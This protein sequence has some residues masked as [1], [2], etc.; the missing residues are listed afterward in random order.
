MRGA[1][2]VCSR[3]I[4]DKPAHG[5]YSGGEIIVDFSSNLHPEPP[6]ESILNAA[7][8]GIDKSV[9][10]P[11]ADV[12][13]FRDEIGDQLGLS[14]ELI[15]VGAGSSSL[16]YALLFTLKPRAVVLPTPCFSEYPYLAKLAGASIIEHSTEQNGADGDAFEQPPPIPPKSCVLLSNPVNPTGRLIPD[17][18]LRRWRKAAHEAGGWIIVD[19][20]YA[21]FT[22]NGPVIHADDFSDETMIVLRSPLKFY[23]LPGLRAGLAASHTRISARLR[24]NLPPWPI[25]TPAVYAWRAALQLPRDA[26]H[27]RRRRVRNWADSFYRALTT[28]PALQMATSDVHFFLARLS[29]EAPDGHALSER[30]AGEGLCI[31]TSDG[32]P[33]LSS[34]HIRISTRYPEENGK[35][36]GALKKIYKTES[37]GAA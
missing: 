7:R 20:A 22:E 27:I 31:R 1:I 5:G 33:G 4:T 3:D 34:R 37:V 35:L 12:K 10:Y 28:I 18:T 21:D 19:E 6:P 17:E 2:R 23:T 32:M 9:R 29:A 8:I 15:S 16:L 24:A 26:V 11:E 36:V 13:S 14:P 25:S 30:L